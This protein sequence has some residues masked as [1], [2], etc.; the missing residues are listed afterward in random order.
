MCFKNVFNDHLALEY[1]FHQNLL[2]DKNSFPPFLP[3]PG[4]II[5]LCKD[6]KEFSRLETQLKSIPGL[7]CAH[8]RARSSCKLLP[9]RAA[10]LQPL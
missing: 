5:N 1:N 10:P 8:T 7:T 6:Y 4:R 3:Q 9:P 2:R